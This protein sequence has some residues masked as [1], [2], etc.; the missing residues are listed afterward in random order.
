MFL[1]HARAIFRILANQRPVRFCVGGGGG[2]KFRLLLVVM[3]GG[4]GVNRKDQNKHILN[5][6]KISKIQLSE[7]E[8]SNFKLRSTLDFWECKVNIRS[9]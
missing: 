7:I 8:F 1:T 9:V 2:L 4:V 3:V 5:L 6:R